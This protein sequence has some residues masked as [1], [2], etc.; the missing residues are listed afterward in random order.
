MKKR[1][2]ITNL[3]FSKPITYYKLLLYLL[4]Q[5]NFK[6]LEQIRLYSR[7]KKNLDTYLYHLNSHML[8]GI[9]PNFDEDIFKNK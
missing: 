9:R 7:S 6:T 4:Q 5:T 1:R 8:D 3:S 2:N